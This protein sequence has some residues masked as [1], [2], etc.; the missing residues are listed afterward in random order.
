MGDHLAPRPAA[1]RMRCASAGSATVAG[2]RVAREC[3][4]RAVS[5]ARAALEYAISAA[6]FPLCL[7]QTRVRLATLNEQS[8]LQANLGKFSLYQVNLGRLEAFLSEI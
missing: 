3:A 8:S 6:R 7:P 1:A 4:S 5:A 2:T